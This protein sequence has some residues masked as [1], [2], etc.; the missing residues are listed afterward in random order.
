MWRSQE[1]GNPDYS[2][3]L[4]TTADIGIGVIDGKSSTAANQP[5]LIRPSETPVN[6]ASGT[7]GVKLYDVMM[8]EVF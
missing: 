2:K 1:A 4:Q 7:P 3:S 6:R 5:F 8:R